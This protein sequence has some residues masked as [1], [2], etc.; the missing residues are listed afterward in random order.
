MIS[1][2]KR[3]ADNKR[4]LNLS[5]NVCQPFLENKPVY[6][7]QKDLNFV[8]CHQII[9]PKRTCNAKRKVSRQSRQIIFQQF[10]CTFLWLRLAKKRKVEWNTMHYAYNNDDYDDSSINKAWSLFV[11]VGV[12]L[13]IF[14]V[15]LTF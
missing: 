11:C 10:F 4:H 5:K 2:F 15:S 7:N 12:F 8:L 3:E 6:V 9:I 1:V 14:E 13:L